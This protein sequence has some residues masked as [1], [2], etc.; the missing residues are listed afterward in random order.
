MKL[1]CPACG[2]TASLEA[3][4]NDPVIRYVLERVVQLPSPVLVN[5][6]AYLGLFRQNGKALPWRR[7]LTVIQGLKDLVGPGHRPLARRRKTAHYGRHMGPGGRGHDRGRAAGIT[8]PQLPPAC[9]LGNGRRAS[10]PA[11]TGTRKRTA[12]PRT[13]QRK[14]RTRAL[15]G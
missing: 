4:R 1:V 12:T 6:P 7:A 15:V 13:R 14:R 2:A 5:C 3:W 10:R 9:R 8:E 11:R